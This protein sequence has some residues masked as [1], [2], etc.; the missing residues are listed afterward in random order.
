MTLRINTIHCAFK[1]LSIATGSLEWEILWIYKLLFGC[2]ESFLCYMFEENFY[3]GITEYKDVPIKLPNRKINFRLRKM[4]K[5]NSCKAWKCILL[6]QTL[7]NRKWGNLV[8][9]KPVVKVIKKVIYIIRLQNQWHCGS[10]TSFPFVNNCPY[11]LQM[12]SW[13]HSSRKSTMT[14]FFM[15]DGHQQVLNQWKA[16][17]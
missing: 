5:L 6:S 15:T 9:K 7:L 2:K 11:S 3:L 8:P 1:V 10:I 13:L 12:V 4:N 14:D 17:N 16:L